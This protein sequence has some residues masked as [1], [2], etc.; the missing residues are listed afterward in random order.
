[1][2]NSSGEQDL[3][4]HVLAPGQRYDIANRA[5][6]FIRTNVQVKDQNFYFKM[7]IINLMFQIN[8]CIKKNY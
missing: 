6:V 8:N 1:M 5:N 4:V 3:I 2:I 7:Y